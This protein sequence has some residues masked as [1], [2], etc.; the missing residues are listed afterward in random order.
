[1]KN[2]TKNII[3]IL[4]I[5]LSLLG[6]TL[7]IYHAKENIKEESMINERMGEAPPEI[8]KKQ[9][10][11]DNQNNNEQIK[12]DE[13]SQNMP[14][15]SE[16]NQKMDFPNNQN[17]KLRLTTPYVIIITIFAL[18][19]SLSLL[20]LIMN[21]KNKS[22]YKNKDKLT[23]YIMSTIILT[24]IISMSLTVLTNNYIL[25]SSNK[26]NTTKEN[27]V[28]DKSNVVSAGVVDLN[29]QK[30][31]VTITS[32][33]TYTIT[34][35]FTNS[36]IID[37][38]DEEVNLILDNVTITNEKTAAIIGLNA[39]KINI[40]LKDGTTN[41]LSDG[42]SSEYDGCI[43]SNTMLEFDGTGTLI[44][45][46]NQEEGEG[47]ATETNDI[48]INSGT[49]Y[50]TSNDDGL[51]AGG[52]GGTITINGGTLYI[53]ASGD[54]I[55]SNKNAI[56]NGGT[57]FVI[58]SDVGGDSGIDTDEGYVINGGTVV[59]LG[60]D[61]IELP[62]DTSLQN[63]LAVT[64]DEKISKD[65][66]VS[67]VSDDSNIISFIAPKS[68]KTIIISSSNLNNGSYSLYK[69]EM[70]EENIDYGITD[71]M[72]KENIISLNNITT[73]EISKTINHYTS[74]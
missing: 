69:E 23:I 3:L 20:Y 56:I 38:E 9:N 58:G 16:D 64:L 11:E 40:T 7:T 57:I 10:T 44:V 34:G 71:S 61:M 74:R 4:V 53:N 35:T 45:S 50:I 5:V 51:N 42:G 67:L 31:D 59:A 37:A 32:G 14:K 18:T 8:E 43:Y 19:L 28:L 41:T 54:G 2:K 72:T 62:D 73:F 17:N 1:M 46:G 26:T 25:N 36:V 27:V 70:Q 39:S 66:L 22:F 6:L 60:T 29:S 55:D 65:T 21:I 12:P 49:Y 52:D 15:M 68:F 30:T 13:S 48:T 24:F 63:A 47:I 33:G